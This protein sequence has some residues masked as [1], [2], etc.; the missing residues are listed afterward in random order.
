[1]FSLLKNIFDDNAKRIKSY[2]K[3]ITKINDFEPEITKLNDEE[4]SKKSNYFRKLIKKGKTLDDILPE[5]FAVVREA[6]KRTIGERAYD[7]QLMSAITLHQGAIAEQK[8]GEG[9]TH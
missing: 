3:I 2:Q 7:V 5:A 4:L 6:V 8:T 1:M 9:K